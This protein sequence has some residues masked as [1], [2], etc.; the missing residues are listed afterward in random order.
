M[1]NFPISIQQ[2]IHH[3]YEVI[4]N[5]QKVREWRNTIEE[6]LERS[7]EINVYLME[8]IKLLKF[9]QKLEKKIEK[10]QMKLK[11]MKKQM[12]K[13]EKQTEVKGS[14]PCIDLVD[15]PD[16]NV[17][18]LTFVG[19]KREIYSVCSDYDY[20]NVVVKSEPLTLE[21]LGVVTT[22]PIFVIEE[23]EE[24]F[25]PALEEEVEEDIEPVLEEDFE[26]ALEPEK[27]EEEEVVEEEVEEE[28]EEEVVE[29]EVEEEEEEEVVEEEVKE[30]EVEEEEE[31]EV[32]EEEQK[33]EIENK[34]EV[35]EQAMEDE[36]EFYEKEISG[37]KYYVSNEKNSVI[38]SFE[39][40]EEI[41]DPVGK[42]VD[43]KPV[44]DKK[45][46]EVEV[47]EEEEEEFYMIKI[48]NIR[49]YVTNETNSEIYAY[50]KDGDLGDLVGNYVDGKPTFK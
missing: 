20:S 2:S 24:D 48:K 29:E 5:L 41:G 46:E 49:Y 25:E 16:D 38:Y 36:E 9:N 4:D 27:E 1:S 47:E 10:K 17:S 33:T 30:E 34:T 11:K 8:R 32:V 39:E 12:K 7:H 50:G 22:K 19:A 18:E 26:P 6:D 21:D 14:D 31:E 13:A 42:Y 28:E 43:G 45:V 37:N 15:L 23:E 40:D 35:K 3:L 44:F